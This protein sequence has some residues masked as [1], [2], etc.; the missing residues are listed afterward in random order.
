MGA[1]EAAAVL[2]LDL[3]QAVGRL[4]PQEVEE[5]RLRLGRRPTAVMGK[6]EVVLSQRGVTAEDLRLTLENA[7]QCSAHTVLDK[8]RQGF[9]TIRGGH[10]LGL[11]GT[12]VMEGDRM[13][14]LRHLSSVALRVAKS[15][16][17]AGETV[18]PKLVDGEGRAMSTLILSPPGLGKTTLLRDLIRRFSDGLGAAPHRVGLA[19]ER[20]EVAALWEGMPQQ[21]VGGH[22]DVMDGCPKAV[23]LLALLR[24]MNPQ[25]LA[26]DELTHP[27]DAKALVQAAGCGVTLLCTAHGGSAADLWR[28][29]V[30][31]HLM[32]LGIFQRVVL[33]ARKGG[34]RSYQVSDW[35]DEGR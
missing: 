17:T 23:G 18:L 31:R 30:Y 1:L 8:V 22:T 15:V 7:S 29:P 27:D 19:D 2:P 3:R 28:R 5:L 10:R 6:E 9:V 33:I 11:C 12:A 35:E 24:G 32:E 13:V 26:T 4:P 14:N 16:P 21:D 34:F 25:L 20:G